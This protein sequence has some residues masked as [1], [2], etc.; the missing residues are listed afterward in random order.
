MGTDGMLYRPTES[1]EKLSRRT[2]KYQFD[3]ERDVAW[4]AD[5]SDHFAPLD[6]L[7]D[8]GFDAERLRAHPEALKALAWSMA[9]VVCR[10]FIVLEKVVVRFVAEGG[11]AMEG[12]RSL[13]LL[14]TEEVKHIELFRRVAEKIASRHPEWL[15][16]FED[17]YRPT[18]EFNEKQSALNFQRDLYTDES[19]RHYVFWLGLIFFEEFTIYLDERFSGDAS[20][21]GLWRSAHTC[22]RREEVQ[23]VAT[24]IAYIDAL[25]VSDDDRSFW[26]DVIVAGMVRDL[27]YLTGLDACDRFLSNL[28]PDLGSFAPETAPTDAPFLK[29][30]RR[31]TEFK[32]T[33]TYLPS[34]ALE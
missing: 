9:L 19:N 4:D 17:A 8:I 1:I 11:P 6:Y 21:N 27:R 24:D 3:L 29:E 34:L 10:N 26:G 32:R 23:H 25:D 16:S 13:S 7:Q 31:R 28:F 20:L 15:A 30:L 2:T 33:R 12:E 14:S 18:A 5:D 22:H